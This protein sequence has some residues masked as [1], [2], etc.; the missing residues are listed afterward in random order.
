MDQEC[1][2]NNVY[3]GACSTD[4]NY[5]KN[6]GDINNKNNRGDTN[7]NIS[8][9]KTYSTA[10]GRKFNDLD[11]ETHIP[12]RTEAE[13]S[14]EY[15]RLTDTN[16]TTPHTDV[17]HSFM[18]W[19]I[20]GMEPRV[21]QN[22]EHLQKFSLQVQEQQPSVIMIQE[23]RLRCS[24][25]AGHGTVNPRDA[26][27]LAKFMT[28]LPDYDCFPSLCAKKYAG[29]VCLVLIIAEFQNVVILGT[30]TP[31]SGNL[32]SKFLARRRDFD[33]QV[34]TFASNFATVSSKPLIYA[35]DL[36]TAANL[37]DMSHSLDYYQNEALQHGLYE[38]STD[39][40]DYSF[41]GT[42]VNERK[43]FHILLRNA[44]LCD[45]GDFP[46]YKNN[47]RHFTWI[48]RHNSFYR[49]CALRLDYI[50]VSRRLEHAGC[51][52]SYVNKARS[53]T[54]LNFYGSDHCPIFLEL[55]LDWPARIRLANSTKLITNPS[56]K[57]NVKKA[58]E[59]QK[60]H[61][62]SHKD[63]NISQSLLIATFFF[64]NLASTL[65]MP[66]RA[67][68]F[69][70]HLTGTILLPEN[71]SIEAE[72][73]FDSGCIGANY[74]SRSFYNK[75][76]QE[77]A[78][79]TQTTDARVFLG[80][81]VTSKPI[82]LM[83]DLCV[84]YIYNEA[85]HQAT[86]RFGIL[87]GEGRDLII[88]NPTIFTQFGWLYH[89]MV[90]NAVNQYALPVFSG[91][92]D[93]LA[94]NS[95][96]YRDQ[97]PPEG[98]IYPWTKDILEEAPED[99]TIPEASS[100]RPEVLQFLATTHA[101][102][103]LKFETFLKTNV[104][105]DFLSNTKVRDLLI[106]YTTNFVK[107]EW[108]GLN[109]DPVEFTFSD[110]MP[111]RMKPK[112]HPIPMKLQEATKKEFDRLLGYFFE[113]CQSDWASPLTV[114]PK[115]T[116]PFVRL[117]VNLQ[118]VN[119]YI[120]FGHPPIPNVQ[121][122]L[123]KLKGFKYFLDIDARN[124]YHQ[125]PLADET[126]KRLSVQTPW[127]Q[128]RP[129]FLCEGTCN[130]TAVFQQTMMDIFNSLN[131]EGEEEW[132]FVL[133][134]NFLIGAHSHL[135][136][137]EKLAKFLQRAKDFNVYLKMEKT[138]L[139]QTKQHF[140]G[141]DIEENKFSMSPDRA[142][143]L[144]SVPFPS[145]A[146]AAVNATA[147]RSFLGQTRIFQP[148]VP[149][150]SEISGPLDEMTSKNFNWDKNTWLKLYEDIFHT[151]KA[152]LKETMSLF[153]PNYDYDWILRTDASV[154]GYGGVLY[155]NYI[156]NAGK[157]VFEPL[158][159]MSHKFSDPATRWD[160]FTQECYAI[161]ACIKECEYLL[162]G[163]PFIIETDHNNLLWLEASQV[164]KIIR[165]HLYIRSFTT[166]I[167]HVPGKSNTADYWSRLVQDS[168]TS[169]TL[170]ALFVCLEHES[171]DDFIFA[172]LGTS[173]VI[174]SLET[175]QKQAQLKDANIPQELSHEDMLASVHG[176]NMLHQGARRT[177][178]L[179]NQVYP[180]HRIP[181][182]T[183]Q[184]YI[185]NCAICQKHKQGLRDTLKPYYRVLKPESHRITVGI[186][187]LTIT[188]TDKRGFTAIITIVN[189]YTHFVYLYPVKSH[190]A[191]EMA[192]A[193]MSYICNFGLIDE[194][195]S[196]PGSELMSK[197][198]QELNAWLGL[199]HKVSL[200]DVHTSNGCENS[201]RQVIEH[202]SA[203][204]SDL[205]LKDEWSDPL[206]LG[207]IQFH[208]NSSLSREA[209]IA[210]F[211][212]MFGSQDDTYYS[213]DPK[214]A[215]KDIQT[216]Y[217]Q[218]LDQ[219]LKTLREISSKHQAHI[220]KERL[221]RNKGMNQFVVGD[222]V[223]KTV[224]TPTHPWKPEK[225]GAKFT[226]PWEVKSVYLNDYV[227]DHV[228]Q[229]ITE[230]FH[231]EMLKPFFGSLEEAK[232]VALLDFNQHF[233][234][235]VRGYCGNPHKRKTCEFFVEFSDGDTI[236][237]DWDPDLHVNEAFQRF[238]TTTPELWPL[239]L[240][241]E[242]AIKAKSAINKTPI[243]NLTV[244]QQIYVDLRAIGVLWYN[245][246]FSQLVLE[247]GLPNED[248][249]TYV[250]PFKVDS[251]TRDRMSVYVTCPLLNV[252][253]FWKHDQ[254]KSW[255]QYHTMQAS[256]ILVDESFLSNHFKVK[257][258]LKKL[259]Q[260]YTEFINKSNSTKNTTSRPGRGG[261]RQ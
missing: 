97:P 186:D 89:T 82:S 201:N 48:G 55:K 32:S 218:L 189:Q 131:I 255:G 227:C 78:P 129:K 150:Y 152:R 59:R 102:E 119:K 137:Y 52:Q 226:G 145:S 116:D 191:K 224:T 80:D 219:S 5:N 115:A 188:P 156:D 15:S 141:Y 42:A 248:L 140:F 13:F 14:A 193:I 177:W 205:R 19:N 259:E 64:N 144:E 72:T 155:Q 195:L 208:F 228:T 212:A 132:L 243:Q 57:N 168:T 225:I 159:F 120:R 81:F 148:F 216:S 71:K 173:G 86:I 39:P 164:P 49:D 136:A 214:L 138:H 53:S 153:Y 2:K 187:T 197:A 169:P 21:N 23:V 211:H 63:A 231:V 1:I 104:D 151:F 254:V 73:L 236:W 239:L 35:G 91:F 83:L 261:K 96:S 240:T 207:L 92:C 101:E 126:S 3:S 230:T 245:E 253:L 38:K 111:E 203:I 221:S 74:M 112:A 124:G 143:A 232:K 237:C 192:N 229:N 234:N 176:G 40:N 235:S 182:R 171:W 251:F 233:V 256:H 157:K 11:N 118:R 106:E 29:Q 174:E 8:N 84:R 202:L 47:S 154:Y 16:L 183:V 33:K 199:R 175:Y 109:I 194:I 123:H 108:K 149:D 215:I 36:N 257:E 87:E 242:E 260:Y 45:P 147:M 178:L 103:L 65:T 27:I 60:K 167:R 128:F 66:P 99:D 76:T 44:L 134:D 198:I 67:Q 238:C 24:E 206:I 43:R 28:L 125:V 139:G 146:K 56:A 88:G 93:D 62:V 209:G 117:C 107:E 100:F 68:H 133:H 18:T 105:A 110:D 161:F 217:I 166:W 69:A 213:L 122:T 34:L 9:D 172:G 98:A 165:Q 41:P 210:P 114:A 77:L 222:L 25:T 223:L 252:V 244:G 180:G 185:E 246:V 247:A 196:D 7:N 181:L 31:C 142:I 61:A 258:S 249:S 160:T 75:H 135:D 190:T 94:V 12:I 46:D 250:V 4:N 113:P 163:K 184:E 79:Y 204:T 10:G 179:L 85:T 220:A 127:G 17:P 170:Q 22:W 54:R 200:T 90:T 37:S 70:V 158:K 30:Y 121:H 95:I 20:D 50:L 6:R 162:R 241:S 26:P 58:R 51:I 130:G